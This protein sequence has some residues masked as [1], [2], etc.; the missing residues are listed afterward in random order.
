MSWA[1]LDDQA[2]SHPK[3]RRALAREP[4]SIA[5]WT[6][7][8]SWAANYE[9]DGAVPAFVVE[10]LPSEVR[11]RA[12]EALLD[13]RLWTRNG[14]GFEIHDYLDFNPSHAQLEKD[15]RAN[16]RR[17]RAYRNRKRGDA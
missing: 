12:I 14:D 3:V 7:G 16:R 1:R 10:A 17:Q 5:L 11:E 13:T 9:T 15:R 6:I 8:L 2:H 4:A